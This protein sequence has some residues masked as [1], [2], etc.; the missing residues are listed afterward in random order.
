MQIILDQSSVQGFVDLLDPITVLQHA[1]GI[2][3]D[4][5]TVRR[6]LAYRA[7]RLAPEGGSDALSAEVVTALQPGCWGL[8][9]AQAANS[10]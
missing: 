4:V 2:L 5:S 1:R 6:F 9:Q 10:R 8:C 3:R 7:V